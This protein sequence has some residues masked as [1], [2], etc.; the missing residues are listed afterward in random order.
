[1]TS[2]RLANAQ[3]DILRRDERTTKIN[4][5]NPLIFR[6]LTKYTIYRDSRFGSLGDV[7]RSLHEDERIRTSPK[8]NQDS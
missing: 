1:V 6:L 3:I 5:S 4:D 7:T 2:L 8:S